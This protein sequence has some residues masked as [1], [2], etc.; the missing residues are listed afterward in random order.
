M[1]VHAVSDQHRWVIV[2]LHFASSSFPFRRNKR[3]QD[4]TSNAFAF[5]RL[6]LAR[7]MDALTPKQTYHLPSL[8]SMSQER[9]LLPQITRRMDTLTPAQA[10]VPISHQVP[11][12]EQELHTAWCVRF[13]F[14]VRVRVFA[15]M[16]AFVRTCVCYVCHCEHD[17][18]TTTPITHN[19]QICLQIIYVPACMCQS[20]GLSSSSI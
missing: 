5:A 16:C 20:R 19:T 11:C 8:I 4:S 3:Q 13:C 6:Q 2:C 17:M 7:R 10:K 15:C 1:H 12:P 14:C 18:H 9:K